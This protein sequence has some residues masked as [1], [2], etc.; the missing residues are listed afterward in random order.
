MRG[1]ALCPFPR[2]LRPSEGMAARDA[3]AQVVSAPGGLLGPGLA[4]GLWPFRLP[5]AA[6]GREEGWEAASSP[7]NA[8]SLACT[9]AWGRD[10]VCPGRAGLRVRG[11][12]SGYWAGA[13]RGPSASSLGLENQPLSSLH[14]NSF[15]L[16]PC[17]GKGG[18][19]LSLGEAA[20]PARAVHGGEGTGT[21]RT[22][23]IWHRCAGPRRWER[24]PGSGLLAAS[25][26]SHS[27]L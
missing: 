16:T 10:Q 7:A 17:S 1:G 22:L 13:P 15:T 4:P 12:T 18:K 8:R 26:D 21:C 25:P 23:S 2:T 14:S 19:E 24:A 3:R 11:R 6:E 27:Q 20:A 9:W 5:R